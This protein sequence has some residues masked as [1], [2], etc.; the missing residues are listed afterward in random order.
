MRALLL[1]LCSLAPSIAL[2]AAPAPVAVDQHG[3][4]PA[5]PKW[6]AVGASAASFQVLRAADASV[7]LSGP[8]TLRRASD[9]A[10]GSNVYQGDF[11]GLSE[12]GA[13]YVHVPG[14]GDS[15]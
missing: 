2:A 4:A 11:S 1:L 5:E 6:V 9:P 13:F 10:S 14:V 15:P 3:Y 12:T 8:L 7:A